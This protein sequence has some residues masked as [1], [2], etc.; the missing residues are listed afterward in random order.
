MREAVAIALQR[1]GDASVARLLD[2]LEGWV[3][4]SRL[5]QRAAVAAICE[6]RLLRDRAQTRR[7]IA[8][9]ERVT[10]SV[11]GAGDDADGRRVL[12]QALGYGWSVL[13]AADPERGK[14]AFERLLASDNPDIRWIVRENLK[15]ARL[16]RADLAWTARI[17]DVAGR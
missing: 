5:E 1:Y 4:G 13:I 17:R 11:A 15:K 2:E 14:P 8:L 9:V 16:E 6:P 3:A 10:A 7:A 12:R